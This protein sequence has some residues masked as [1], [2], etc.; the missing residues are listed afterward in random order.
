MTPVD[1]TTPVEP[2]VVVAHDGD[3]SVR[4]QVSAL[5]SGGVVQRLDSAKMTDEAGLFREFADKLGFPSYFGHNWYALVDCLDDLHSSG[6][7]L[8]P[9][10]VVTEESDV[11]VGRTFFPTL[12]SMLC[13]AAERANLSLD[14]DDLPRDRPPFPLHFVFFVNRR[15]VGDV[16]ELLAVREDLVVRESGGR[17]L[18]CSQPR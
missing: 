10:V 15:G 7:G 8:L 1:F 14:A 16:A 12:L 2:W 3:R 18:V 11:L 17:L 9:V 13:E 6:H 5:E 4:E